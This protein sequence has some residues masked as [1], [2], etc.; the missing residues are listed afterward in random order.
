[1]NTFESVIPKLRSSYHRELRERVWG[2]DGHGGPPSNADKGSKISVL[3]ARNM[4]AGTTCTV[5]PARGQA[6]GARFAEITKEFIQEA[7]SKLNHVRSGKWHYSTLPGREGITAFDQYRHL[8]T[9]KRILEEHQEDEEFRTA[10]AS[11]Y[12]IIPDIVI[13]RVPLTDEEINEFEP[14]VQSGHSGAG[15]TPLRGTNNNSLMILH[16]SISC[17]WTIRSDRAQNTRTEALNLIRNRK[18]NA[19]HIVVVTA[20]PMPTRLASLALGTGDLDCVYHMSLYEL[21]EALKAIDDESQ[22]DML[23]L[24]VLGRRLRDITDLPFDLAI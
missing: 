12:L 4:L 3:I 22:Q 6:A 1:M 13:G 21:V 24:L 17:K 10:F 20:E 5:S 19:P 9:L 23:N 8:A 18:G 11:D 7:F 16:A 14:L 15:L 2:Y